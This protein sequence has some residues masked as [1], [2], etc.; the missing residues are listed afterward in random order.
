ML[1]ANHPDLPAELRAGRLPPWSVLWLL[2][3]R[4]LMSAREPI[5]RLG[6]LYGIDS[7]YTDFFGKRRQ[8]P[9]ATER[10]LLQA[11]GA[12]VGSAREIAD[13]LREAE[14]RPWRRMLA[15]VRV[16]A[17]PEPPEVTFTLPAS[18]GRA[19]I[20]WTLSEETGGV[21]EGRLTPDE[22]PE[23][24]AAEV[25]GTA[26]RRWRMALP[27]D[28]PHGYHRLSMAVRGDAHARGSLQLIVAPA[29]CHRPAPQSR[30]WGV[31][32][33]LYGVRSQRNWGIGD[34]TDLARADR[35]GRR[36]SAR[37]PSASTRC[38]PC[39]PPTPTTSARTRHPAA[40]S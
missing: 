37:A 10:A 22:L 21:H 16:I 15:P 14:A 4:A 13:S 36:R 6:E 1:F 2:H 17:A 33:Q 7:S 18:L 32:A 11:M 20:D 23:V 28:L 27:S 31:T 40:C 24:A 19:T 3:P 39:S 5:R 25:D 34:F 29:R 26:Y 9:L 8:V 12:A 38:T 30:L 35:A